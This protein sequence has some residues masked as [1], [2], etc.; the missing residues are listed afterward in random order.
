MSVPER[1]GRSWMT[2]Q[3]SGFGASASA[4]CSRRTS[5]PAGT[6]MT[7]A[8]ARSVV[9]QRVERV[10]PRIER[11]PVGSGFLVFLSKT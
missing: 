1:P 2:H 9:A 10:L 4:R 7:S 5:T 6:S 11:L 8:F 3:R